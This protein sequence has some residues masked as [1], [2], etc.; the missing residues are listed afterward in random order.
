MYE[1]IEQNEIR[2]FEEVF[3]VKLVTYK[4]VCDRCNGEG[5]HDCWD[6]GMTNEEMWELG[7]DFIED[8]CHGTY[9]VTCTEC[10]GNNV[11][12]VIDRYRN[13]PELLKEFDSWMES[14]YETHA[15]WKAE[16]RM[17]A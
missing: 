17:G 6:G 2:K 13:P 8:Y 12:S 10:N 5:S 14:A 3:R 7:Y 16:M 1:V 15:I 11:V 9:S 4:I